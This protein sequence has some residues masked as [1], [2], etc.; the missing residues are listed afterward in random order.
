LI[1]NVRN[2]HQK[3]RQ[4]LLARLQL[5]VGL[6]KYNFIQSPDSLLQILDESEEMCT[7]TILSILV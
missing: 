3:S 4:A 5:F 1:K 6:N 7:A 2:F